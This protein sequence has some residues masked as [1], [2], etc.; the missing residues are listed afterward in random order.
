MLNKQLC[1]LLQLQFWTISSD[2]WL[3]LCGVVT[4]QAYIKDLRR[5]F[6]IILNHLGIRARELLLSQ[7]L[8]LQVYKN[9]LEYLFLQSF[10]ILTQFLCRKDRTVRS[11]VTL[12][13]VIGANNGIRIVSSLLTALVLCTLVKNNQC[14]KKKISMWEHYQYQQVDSSF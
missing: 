13:R 1:Q 2:L 8:A 7:S 10:V 11:N 12:I 3:Y 9:Q 5:S 14:M 6:G 4:P